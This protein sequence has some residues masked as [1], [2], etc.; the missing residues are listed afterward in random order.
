MWGVS[1][2]LVEAAEGLCR[3]RQCIHAWP[4]Q[5][6]GQ[7]QSPRCQGCCL[8]GQPRRVRCRQVP[9]DSPTHAERAHNLVCKHAERKQHSVWMKGVKESESSMCVA[10]QRSDILVASFTLHNRSKDGAG[11]TRV[12]AFTPSGP[13]PQPCRDR[14]STLASSSS[15]CMSSLTPSS[16][17]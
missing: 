14:A 8:G 7:Q 3:E 13:T 16:P 4:W 9:E 6:P 15:A 12:K 1:I 11:L 5:Q 10:I 2:Q 17:I